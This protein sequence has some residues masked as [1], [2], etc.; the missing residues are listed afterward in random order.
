MQGEG[1]KGEVAL[2]AD[3][4]MESKGWE[5]HCRTA[6][7]GENSSRGASW[8]SW[9]R[10]LGVGGIWTWSNTVHLRGASGTKA[11]CQYSSHW[12]GPC[13]P[14]HYFSHLL[15]ILLQDSSPQLCSA[16]SHPHPSSGQKVVYQP[17]LRE[18][19]GF[20]RVCLRGN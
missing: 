2:L 5:G 4:R 17:L 13:S 16:F 15:D 3:G 19:A 9:V 12:P 6:R 11:G 1:F 10:G 18:R 14:T 8:S 7:G 20:S